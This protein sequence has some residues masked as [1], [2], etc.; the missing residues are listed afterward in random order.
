MF[1]L[2]SEFGWFSSD[3]FFFFPKKIILHIMHVYYN[4]SM[5]MHVYMFCVCSL[6]I[7]ISP[8][9][10]H[11][12]DLQ[13]SLKMRE[14]KALL[15]MLMYR[16]TLKTLMTMHPFSLKEFI[17]ETLQKMVQQVICSCFITHSL[18]FVH[19]TL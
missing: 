11:S 2:W 12:G 17:L 1:F 5:I 6:W 15:D 14:E 18:K 9:A 8:L 16:S 10:G 19:C 4:S 3:S 7:E 13:Y